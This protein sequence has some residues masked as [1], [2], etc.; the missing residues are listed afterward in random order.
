[1]RRLFLAMAVC[2]LLVASGQTVNAGLVVDFTGGAP[3][4]PTGDTIGGWE[5]QVTSTITVNALGFWDEGA[6]GLTNRHD[7]GLWDI[8]QNLLAST[9]VTT[10][11]TPVASTSSAGQWLFNAIAPLSLTPGNYVLGATFANN[12]AD[13]ARLNTIA[14]TTAGVTFVTARQSASSSL[15]FPTIL[16][17]GLNAGI[18]G[19]N[20]LT[21]NP[22]TSPV[23]EPAT[24]G[25]AGTA[26]V[27]GLVLARRRAKA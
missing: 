14:T 2:G 15:A 13:L 6:N 24:L 17:P 23:P 27:V 20:L 21:Q 16:S 5:F 22:Q 7:V 9:T 10:A 25:M 1:M 11:S 8:S 12:D 4:S 19:P 3:A 18:F 26:A